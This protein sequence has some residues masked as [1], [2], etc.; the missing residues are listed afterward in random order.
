MTIVD[1]IA[2]TGVAVDRAAARGVSESGARGVLQH[3]A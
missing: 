2:S 1:K 3:F